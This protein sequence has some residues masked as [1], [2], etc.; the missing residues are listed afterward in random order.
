M[1]DSPTPSPEIRTPTHRL[2]KSAL[3]LVAV[4]ALAACGS[5]MPGKGGMGF[6]LTSTGSGDGGNLGGLEIGRAHV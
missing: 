6:F 2:A 1:A 3:A 5:M 4:A